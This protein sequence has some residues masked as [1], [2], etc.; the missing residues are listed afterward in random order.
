MLVPAA[1]VYFGCD[2]QRPS[3]LSMNLRSKLSDPRA[4]ALAAFESR[5][6][7]IVY[8]IVI[9]FNKQYI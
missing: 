2:S 4:A 5:Y 7:V 8:V 6:N 9:Y 1:V 3:Y